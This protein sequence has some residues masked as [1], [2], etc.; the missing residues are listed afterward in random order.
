MKAFRKVC[1]FVP[2]SLL[3]LFSSASAVEKTPQPT[4]SEDGRRVW[5]KPVEGQAISIATG[6]VAYPPG[7]RIVLNIRFKNFGDKD[8]PF[9]IM[10]ILYEYDVAVSLVGGAD[11]DAVYD[12]E[13]G[14]VR[15]IPESGKV[16]HTLLGKTSLESGKGG[17]QFSRRAETRRVPLRRHRRDEVVRLQPGR[18]IPHLRAKARM[19]R[20]SVPEGGQVER[21]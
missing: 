8:V 19:G 2:L 18:E 7:E 15:A 4:A 14:A 13:H 11:R 21:A 1:C 3:A 16:P 12:G 9:R 20:G 5:G 6:R 17:G 10:N